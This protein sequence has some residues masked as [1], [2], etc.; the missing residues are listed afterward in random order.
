[1]RQVAPG[2]QERI[3]GTY[4]YERKMAVKDEFREHNIWGRKLTQGAVVL[5]DAMYDRFPNI[6]QYRIP[7]EVADR[8]DLS[9][10][11]KMVYGFL[12]NF[13]AGVRCTRAE[14]AG[15]CGITATACTNAIYDLEHEGLLRQ[16]KYNKK[17]PHGFRALPSYYQVITPPK[18]YREQ[19]PPLF[20]ETNIDNLEEIVNEYFDEA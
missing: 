13:P 6:K 16:K 17:V 14:I 1:M 10:R 2:R 8:V 9:C 11:A 15:M 4:E 18:R 3:R 19:R 20:T 12:S 7:R 5:H